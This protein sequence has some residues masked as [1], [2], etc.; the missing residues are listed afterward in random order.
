MKK[1]ELMRK[2]KGNYLKCRRLSTVLMVILVMML[3]VI[4]F[5]CPVRAEWF[6]DTFYVTHYNIAFENDF[7][8]NFVT[9][10][11]I[12]GTYREDFLYSATGV[13]MQGTGQTRH[14]T[15][16]RWDHG[17][18]WVN[19]DGVR[20]DP[21]NWENGP[22]YWIGN[23]NDVW[24]A[25]GGGGS[26]GHGVTPGTSVATDHSVLPCDMNIFIEGIGRR[27]V[28]DSGPAIT[29]H[30]I[31][32]LTPPSVTNGNY[33]VYVFDTEPPNEVTNLQSSSHNNAIGQWNDPQ[34]QDNAITV[35]WTDATDN[36]QGGLPVE[37]VANGLDGYSVVWDHSP[38]TLP[39][40]TIEVQEGI[41]S[42]TSQLL[43]DGTDW[44]FHIR[45]AD[46]EITVCGHVDERNWD[47]TAVHLGPFYIDTTP[48][49]AAFTHSVS[50][51]TVSFDASGS[52][53][54][55]SGIDRYEWNFGDGSTGSGV[56]PSHTYPD[57][58]TYT[59]TLKVWD[60]AGNDGTGTAQVAHPVEPVP[61]LPTGVLFAVGLITLAGYVGL[62]RRKNN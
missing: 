32:V 27:R 10:N 29:G 18:Y 54:E 42:A 9:A 31:G 2:M 50:E 15:F 3:T 38:N 11:G 57:A 52:T 22:P 60:K 53:D 62:K 51:L 28:D 16:I 37:D 23:P 49:T 12:S 21:P 46:R 5:S 61:E 39:D 35:T 17:G 59:V 19:V 7:N 4:S 34:S 58:G 40:K 25:P 43:S 36:I 45:S 55:G 30:D 44:Y 41:E 56:S 48:P 47:D 8:G 33:R 6:D 1:I 20:T 13:C 24:F 26:C 14:N